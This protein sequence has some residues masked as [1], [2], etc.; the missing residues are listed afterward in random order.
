MTQKPN[1]SQKDARFT[2]KMR[3]EIET[4]MRRGQIQEARSSGKNHSTQNYGLTPDHTDFDAVCGEWLFSQTR[5]WH[6]LPLSGKQSF[7]PPD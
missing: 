2:S 5:V 3:N 1:K 7:G 4:E 6:G